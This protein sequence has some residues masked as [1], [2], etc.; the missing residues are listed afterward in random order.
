MSHDSQETLY[1]YVHP[2]RETVL[3][4]NQCNRPICTSCAVHTPTGY[5]CKECVRGQLKKF[6]TSQWWDYPLIVITSGTLAW[7]GSLIVSRIMI[8]G[9][10]L[11]VLAGMLIA[12]IVRRVT[13]KRR[14]K[15]TPLVAA[16]AALVGALITPIIQ[17]AAMILIVS[18]AGSTFNTLG[19]LY[20]ILWPVAYALL[21]A[22]SVY[23]RLKG[24]RL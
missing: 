12:E 1:C 2:H 17:V 15:W 13:N 3:R 8:F 24:F 6:D 10:I 5:R 21:I 11:A 16:I 7:L 4:C 20:S 14:S 19:I 9:L 23:Y 18:H 22:G